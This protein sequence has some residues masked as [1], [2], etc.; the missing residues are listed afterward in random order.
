MILV[1][2]PQ[3]LLA[4]RPKDPKRPLCPETLVGH[5]KQVL[6]S[7]QTLFGRLEFPSRLVDEWLRFFGLGSDS[8]PEFYTNGMATAGL[9]DV[10]KSNSGFQEALSGGVQLLY[11]E[12]LSGLLMVLPEVEE[13]LKSISHLDP[14]LVIGAVI[15]HHLRAKREEFASPLHPDRKRFK[16]YE[17]GI[18]EVVRLTG[19]ILKL[20]AEI[21]PMMD[22]VWSFE[23]ASGLIHL[24]EV[25][26]KKMNLFRRRLRCEEKARRLLMAI[27][28]ALIVADSA[29]S[30]LVRE[31]KD[32]TSWLGE[33]FP[34]RE[35][36][37]AEEIQAKVI[38][39]RLRQI[40]QSGISFRWND[41]QD[42]AEHLAPRTLLL[43]SCGS[44]KTLAAWR[45]IKG[46][47]TDKPTGRVIF[48]YPTRATATE[49]FRDYVSWA[50]E[51]DAALMH[52]TSA[53]ELENLFDNPD[54]ERHLKDFTTQERLFAIGYWPRRIFSATI[55]Q[56]LGFMQ[57]VYKSVCLLPLL[58]DSVVVV[59][60]VHSFDHSLFAA[61]KRFLRDFD[62]PVLAMTASLP[63]QRCQDLAEQC[64]MEVFPEDQRQFS[65][66][67]AISNLPRYF[68]HLIDGPETARGVAEAELAKGQRVLWVVNTVD[69]CQQLALSLNA[70]CYHSRFK[71][72][73]RRRRHQEVIGAFQHRRAAVLTLTTQVCEMSLDLDA[74]V[75]ITESAP[76]TSLIQRLGRCNRRARP[77]DGKLGD[78]YIYRPEDHHPYH[79]DDLA[80]LNDFLADL[81]NQTCSQS[82]LQELLEQH[83]SGEVEV[84]RYAAFLECGP[85]AVSRESSLRDIN[86]FTVPAVLDVDVER[87]LELRRCRQ[88]ID[89]LLVPAPRRLV[90]TDGRLGR[91][92]GVAPGKHYL[93]RYGLFK[94]PVEA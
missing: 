71:L 19:D 29:G 47:L 16:V 24:R 46:R 30:G 9:H 67:E 10:G 34:E 14:D 8:F 91:F 64:G 69:R 81:D 12:H 89:G 7:F 4:K 82:R 21:R 18:I 33:V 20:P 13:W 2:Q 39:P 88:P 57:N 86:E 11:H 48:L 5:T 73:D 44:G 3:L 94:E 53:Y 84:Q 52:G 36:I 1:Y 56:F 92:P 49:G 83:A 65:D 28:A 79:P 37:T 66:L 23:N 61:F 38:E 17:A 87:F 80:G 25:L 6:T 60:E 85:W 77:K 15:S 54:D 75:L 32:V 93:P 40:E 63:R 58:A 22:T 59:D 43:A 45:W 35:R 50:P 41:F 31:G 62:V 27:R 70:S 74:D 72:E 55:D 42:A 76:I 26:I 90:E 78:I 51:A 68:V